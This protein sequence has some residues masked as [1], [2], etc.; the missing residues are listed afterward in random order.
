MKVMRRIVAFVLMLSVPVNPSQGTTLVMRDGRLIEG[1]LG[2]VG[3]LAENA[4][5]KAAQ[6]AEGGV[7]PIAIMDDDLRRTFVPKFQIAKVQEANAAEVLEKIHIKQRVAVAGARIGKVGSILG[8]GEFDEYGRRIFSMAGEKGRLDVIQGIT[9]ITPLWTKVEGIVGKQPFVW[10]MR[11]ATNAIPRTTLSRI[12]SKNIDPKNL[13]Q[14][15]SLVRLFLQAERY[16]DAQRELEA[17]LQDF[18]QEEQLKT[19]ARAL[20]QLSA[21]R[22]IDEINGR[23]K[24]GQHRLAYTLLDKFPGEDV[25]GE[26]LGQVRELLTEYA[27]TEKQAKELFE[28]LDALVAAMKDSVL[29]G[30]CK[31]ILD[32]IKA[33]LNIYTFERMAAYTRLADDAQLVADDKFS[34]AASGWLMGSDAASTNLTVT[35]SMYQV[36]ELVR[37]YLAE[38]LRNKRGSLLRQL[39]SLEGT[40]VQQVAQIISHMKPPSETPPPENGP[41]GLYTLTVPSIDKE[42]DVT[43]YVQLPPEYDPYRRYPTVITLNGGGTTPLQQIDWWAGAAGD[44]GNR[45]GQASRFGYI[46]ISVDWAKEGQRQYEYSAREHAAVLASLRDAC[47][48]FSVDTDRVF[49]SGHSIGGD[50][51]WDLGL[52][53]PDLWA[54]VIPIV[55]VSDRYCARYFENADLVPFYVVSGELDGDKTKLNSRDIDRYMIRRYDVTVVEYLGRGHENFSDE[56]QRIYDWMGRRQRDF[57]P[58]EFKVSTMRTWDNFFWWLELDNFPHGTIVEPSNWPPP[59]GT[60]PMKVT[61]AIKG[62]NISVTTGADKISVWLAPEMVDFNKPVRVRLNGKSLNTGEN[63]LVEPN[64]ET[65]LEDVRTRGERQHPFWAKIE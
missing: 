23:R 48:R 55:A 2:M 20:R 64:L 38:G 34:L 50:A 37:Q 41:P 22:M 33:E 65:L 16:S 19:E 10:D 40:S 39:M 56:I 26:T 27:N 1:K 47:R 58:K 9:Q 21:K 45:L 60:Q 6:G 12:L 4:F 28:Q 30:R 61:A 18:P 5:Q 46:I 14:R 24:A 17:I 62:N 57:F 53:H 52:A 11:I 7:R 36:R 29:Q 13:D 59:R 31:P 35:L 32:E 3:G 63:L 54:G 25:A 43:Y 42:P 8:I 15:L 44:N 51:A 49:L